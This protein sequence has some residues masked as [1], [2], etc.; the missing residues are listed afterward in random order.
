M[1]EVLDAVMSQYDNNTKS[2]QK[3][4]NISNEDRLKRYFSVNLA[5][6]KDSGTKVF[7]ILP[8]KTGKSPFEESW[9][10]E[11]KI[12]D[13]WKKIYCPKKNKTG[14]CP[15]CTIES[16]LLS[17][18]KKEDQEIASQY[19]ARKFYIVK[20]IDRD[21]ES[22]G[23]KFWRF[24]NNFKKQGVLD[25]IIPLFSA[26]GD[27]SDPEKGR[28]MILTLG[29][30]DKGYT[31]ITSIMPED[32]GP[33]SDDKDLAK[34]WIEDELTSSDVYSKPSFEY[35]EIVAVGEVPYWDKD[36]QKYITKTEWE[37]KNTNG[38][39]VETMNDDGETESV[40]GG[41]EKTV[42]A[43]TKTVTKKVAAKKVVEVVDEDVDTV[44]EE[45]EDLPF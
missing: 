27:I 26:K 23:P 9:Y 24:R 25:K 7:R 13:T 21:R 32:P 34:A 10:H 17:T 41:E 45:I 44:D 38:V 36:A 28:D 37:N 4:S 2:G 22:D 3:K 14:E 16:E 1:S 15:L 29:K 40:I 20:G 31:K 19:R 6:N 8:P 39:S 43:P 5:K 30:D 33:L 35:L 12:G 18:K 11:I 42:E